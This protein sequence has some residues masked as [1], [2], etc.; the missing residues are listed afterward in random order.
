MPRY[1]FRCRQC[2]TTFEIDRP[3]A[4]AG[5]PARCPHGHADTVKLLST[6]ALGGRAVRR[7]RADARRARRRWRLL[8]GRLLRLN[9]RS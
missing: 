6:V 8:R 3:M 2:S 4:A 9:V 7:P 5:D 1:D